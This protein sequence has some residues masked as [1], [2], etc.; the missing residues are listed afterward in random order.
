M[1]IAR[2]CFGL[3]HGCEQRRLRYG[4]KMKL[5]LIQIPDYQAPET[6]LSSS[7]VQLE[8]I[9]PQYRNRRNLWQEILFKFSKL[10][11]LMK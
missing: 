4:G 5:K 1:V 10:L 8:P 7:P 9:Q 2:L 6:E 11:E 3:D